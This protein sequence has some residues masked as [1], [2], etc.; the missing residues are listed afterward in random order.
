MS[1]TQGAVVLRGPF[2]Y[3]FRDR[4]LVFHDY[5]RNVPFYRKKKNNNNKKTNKQTNK[6][7]QTKKHTKKEKR[8]SN[9]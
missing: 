5:K 8:I 3:T 7:K 2:K 6:Q 1:S 4:F 9:L